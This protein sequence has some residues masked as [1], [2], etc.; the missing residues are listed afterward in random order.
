MRAYRY[1]DQPL[2]VRAAILARCGH[3]AETIAEIIGSSPATVRRAKRRGWSPAH[4]GHPTRPRPTDF[5]IQS[6]NATNVELCR[7]YRASNRC[8]NRWRDELRGTTG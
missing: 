4:P 3:D 6:R 5:A 7:I 1:L 8:V 2:C